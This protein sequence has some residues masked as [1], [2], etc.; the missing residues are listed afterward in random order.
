MTYEM[1]FLEAQI[2]GGRVIP[3]VLPGCKASTSELAGFLNGRLSHREDEHRDVFPIYILDY[4][5][6]TIY[7]F[8]LRTIQRL[9]VL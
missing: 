8:V 9:W 6:K 1:T 5:G 3:R 4:L 2:Y 7:W